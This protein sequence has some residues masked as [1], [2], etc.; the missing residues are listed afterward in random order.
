M[1]IKCYALDELDETV[2][3]GKTIRAFKFKFSLYI[4]ISDSLQY[5]L[6]CFKKHLEFNQ[7]RHIA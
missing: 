2:G 6:I 4:Y 7:C 5:F 3:E 1:R